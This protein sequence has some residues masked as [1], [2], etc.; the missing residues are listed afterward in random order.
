MKIASPPIGIVDGNDSSKSSAAVSG[1]QLPAPPAGSPS[2]CALTERELIIGTTH[3]QYHNDH[4]ADK[5][6]KM[7]HTIRQNLFRSK[8]QDIPSMHF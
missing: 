7:A 6:E 8:Q 3:I 1:F 2:Y 5:V 4:F